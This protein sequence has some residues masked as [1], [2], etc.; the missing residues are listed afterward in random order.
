MSVLAGH[1]PAK[2]IYRQTAA[3]I[4][5]KKLNNGILLMTGY[6]EQLNAS[7]PLFTQYGSAHAAALITID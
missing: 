3:M 5:L 1:Y 6:T 7:W 4:L 2:I